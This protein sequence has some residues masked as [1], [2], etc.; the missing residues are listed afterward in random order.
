MTGAGF[1]QGVDSDALLAGG[2]DAVTDIGVQHGMAADLDEDIKPLQDGGVHGLL[3]LDRLT[4][5][6]PPISGR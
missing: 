6:V 1:G 5:V 3:E 2:L 4:D